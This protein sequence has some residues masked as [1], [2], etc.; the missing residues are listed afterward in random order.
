LRSDGGGLFRVDCDSGSGQN[1]EGQQLVLVF[2]KRG[3]TIR[4]WGGLF[5]L[6]P[7]VKSSNF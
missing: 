2:L 6:E 5:S 7:V 1:E 4:F 3:I